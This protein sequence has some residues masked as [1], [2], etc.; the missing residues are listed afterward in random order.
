MS[1]GYPAT[2]LARSPMQRIRI[3][4]R[5]EIRGHSNFKSR[6]DVKLT[7]TQISNRAADAPPPVSWSCD[8]KLLYVS[9]VGGQTVFSVPLRAG[10]ALPPLPAGGL[11]SPEDVARLPGDK[12]FRGGR[13]TQ[14][15]SEGLR[16][17]KIKLPGQHFSSAFA[18]MFVMCGCW[19][20][21]VYR[22]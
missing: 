19:T 5:F 15:Q 7:R 18:L 14:V 21:A 12:R 9:M 11:H 2:F 10:Q 13:V 22:Y 1:G 6:R 17:F 20:G 8:G 4:V 16:V 3:L